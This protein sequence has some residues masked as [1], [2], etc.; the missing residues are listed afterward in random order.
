MREKSKTRHILYLLSCDCVLDQ[1]HIKMSSKNQ[2]T[3]PHHNGA[4]V[5][6]REA[7]CQECGSKI[8]CGARG[9][10]PVRCNS[11]TRAR[12]LERARAYK[13][14]SESLPVEIGT[15]PE[16]K[17]D[18]C[19]YDSCLAAGGRLLSDPGACVCCVDYEQGSELDVMDYVQSRGSLF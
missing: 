17:H 13:R 3:C 12:S 18:C 16:R 5:L 14:R 7:R 1:D 15:V 9:V 8:H 6:A 11:C 19:H 4:K 2:L 10:V